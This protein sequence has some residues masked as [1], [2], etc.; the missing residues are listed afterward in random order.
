MTEQRHGFVCGGSWALDRIKIVDQWPAEETL[1]RITGTDRQGGGS[2]HNLGVDIR[3]LDPTMPVDAIGL[4]GAD[5]DGDFLFERATEAGLDTTQLHRTGDAA[6]RRSNRIRSSCRRAN[7]P[8]PTRSV[9]RAC[10]RCRVR[11]KPARPETGTCHE[12]RRR[13]QDRLRGATQ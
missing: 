3:R 2:A 6:T 7:G 4:L 13:R 9:T 11:C 8:P 5:P 12:K 10:C 1:A